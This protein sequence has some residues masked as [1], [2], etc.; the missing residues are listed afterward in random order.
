MTLNMPKPTWFCILVKCNASLHTVPVTH[1]RQLL[2]LTAHSSRDRQYNTM[3]PVVA[4]LHWGSSRLHTI[5]RVIKWLIMSLSWRHATKCYRLIDGL[6]NKIF[7]PINLSRHSFKR[8]ENNVYLPKQVKSAAH[9]TRSRWHTVLKCHTTYVGWSDRGVCTCDHVP[10]S[11]L[12]GFYGS[13]I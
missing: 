10:S 9:T 1:S 2:W 13:Q 12:V 8:K 6:A 7:T 4:T 5:L 3:Q 11:L